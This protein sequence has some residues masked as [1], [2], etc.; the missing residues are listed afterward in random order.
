MCAGPAWCACA[1]RREEESEG[2]R[3]GARERGSLLP[4]PAKPCAGPARCVRAR[5]GVCGPG[6]VCARAGR[7]RTWSGV[8]QGLQGFTPKGF[9]DAGAQPCAA[10]PIVII[11]NIIIGVHN[12]VNI[13]I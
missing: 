8:L 2:G 7:L 3:E 9:A 6:P 4:P 12:S 1:G 13:I 5:P 11:V 10:R